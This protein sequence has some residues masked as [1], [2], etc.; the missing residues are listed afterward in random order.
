MLTI[1]T[2]DDALDLAATA[3]LVVDLVVRAA[4][5]LLV[6]FLALGF[7]LVGD[8]LVAIE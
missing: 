1:L 2:L 5:T 4:F 6:D 7:A 3:D 8:F